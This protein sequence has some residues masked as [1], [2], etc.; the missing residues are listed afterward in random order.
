MYAGRMNVDD[1]QRHVIAAARANPPSDR[2]PYGFERRVM[3]RV[4]GVKAA[5]AWAHW[6]AALWRAAAPC[7][8]VALL[9]AVWS[10]LD[11]SG[12]GSGTSSDVSQQFENMVLAGATIDQVPSEPLR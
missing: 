7:V 4:L 5:D 9:L 2:V 12:N 8:A 11:G 10:M 6:A 3:N 1:I